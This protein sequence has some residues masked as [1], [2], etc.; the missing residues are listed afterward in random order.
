M[1]N[2]ARKPIGY[3]KNHDNVR[4]AIFELKA[5]TY[6][7]VTDEEFVLKK[8]TYNLIVKERLLTMY[9]HNDGIANIAKI[10]YPNIDNSTLIRQPKVAKGARKPPGYWN[11][12]KN[13]KK[14]LIDLK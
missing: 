5:R 12:H 3:W 11:D 1:S 4:N 6:P 2:Q 9:A 8:L 7:A 13:I 14:A 10:A